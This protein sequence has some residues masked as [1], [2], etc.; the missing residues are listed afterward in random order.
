MLLIGAKSSDD[1]ITA[2]GTEPDT[3]LMVIVYP[4]ELSD[5][6]F[7]F[8]LR[9]YNADEN[10]FESL[11]MGRNGAYSL[12]GIRRRQLDIPAL[13]AKGLTASAHWVPASLRVPAIIRA[14]F[15][16]ALGNRNTLVHCF[17]ESVP[18]FDM[19]AGQAYYLELFD[20]ERF[21]KR[22]QGVTRGY[23]RGGR[24]VLVDTRRTPM[25][26]SAFDD[27]FDRD[28][29]EI[30]ESYVSGANASVKLEIAQTQYRLTLKG[31]TGRETEFGT[32]TGCSE[33]K[34]DRVIRPPVP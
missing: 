26:A 1:R 34:P 7:E 5:D 17:R 21:A 16:D 28:L 23:S 3:A 25:Y 13:A 33:V 9:E 18:V 20:S 11:R 27:E 32:M 8:H 15:R 14:N 24:E 19:K 29:F 4:A 2:F 31:Q 10:K 6:M 30:V 22:Q 12:A